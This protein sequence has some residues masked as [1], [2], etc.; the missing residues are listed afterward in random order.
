MSTKGK[1]WGV[2]YSKTDEILKMVREECSLAQIAR[3]IG[4]NE[5]HIRKRLQELGVD[6]EFPYTRKGPRCPAWR[7]GR[8]VDK[9][10][11]I[12]VLKTDHPNADRHGYVREHRLVMEQHLGRLLEPREVVHHLNKKRDD[13][14]IENL[15]LYA[16]NAEHLRAELTGHKPNWTPDGLEKLKVAI[17]RSVK[18][19][20]EKSLR[21][22]KL[23]AQACKQKNDLTP[24]LPGIN[25]PSL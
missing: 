9:H 25:E 2:C 18:T 8:V 19:R 14:Q 23:C 10:G 5:R 13:N 3:T 12:L 17:A 7:G 15:S 24:E 21:R 22:L 4:T 1:R 11:Y 16:S 20:K 6:A